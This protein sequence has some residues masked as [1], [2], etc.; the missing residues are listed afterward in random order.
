MRRLCRMAQTV[1]PNAWTGVTLHD[2]EC[3]LVGASALDRSHRDWQN[4]LRHTG[5]ASCSAS[6]GST[7]SIMTPFYHPYARLWLPLHALGWI[8]M[9]GLFVTI[10]SWLEI[11]DL[12]PK[13]ERKPRL[14]P[15][16][17]LSAICVAALGI[18]V[19]AAVRHRDESRPGVLAPTDSLKVACRSIAA[20]LPKGLT[21]LRL[22]GRPAIGFYLALE[23]RS[24]AAQSA[25]SRF[26]T[27]TRRTIN[28]GAV[29][30]ALL[31]QDGL[32][33]DE[34]LKRSN[35]WVAARDFP[36]NLNIPTLLD[37]DP[38]SCYRGSFDLSAPILLLQA[39]RAEDT[40]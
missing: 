15:M 31:R 19:T 35:H 20:E 29:D 2:T 7:L 38:G 32:S 22:F 21:D 25:R 39:E 17:A 37:I 36:S 27:K 6:G 34:P 18:A 5:D 9:G 33:P 12:R 1:D 23:N 3:W 24:D 26:P 4:R 13:Q 30:S 10:R 28:L 16:L 8:V 14:N 40:R 11:A